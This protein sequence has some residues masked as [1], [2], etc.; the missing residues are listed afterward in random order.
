MAFDFLRHYDADIAPEL[1]AYWEKALAEG[2]VPRWE[3]REVER[4][5]AG[6]R[7]RLPPPP[8]PQPRAAEGTT[9]DPGSS[10][11]ALRPRPAGFVT[12][13]VRQVM[14]WIGT[15][16]LFGGESRRGVD[17]SA[18]T[19]A[20]YRDGFGVK[21]PRNARAQYEQGRAVSAKA[22]IPGDL[23]FFDTLDRGHVTHVGVYVGD[24]RFAHASS[25]R[26]VVIVA[27]EKPYYQHAWVGARRLFAAP[28]A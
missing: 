21:L 9:G 8:R 2:M 28:D 7:A 13:L 20:V 19:R 10:R 6:I 4:V 23:L 18:F 15:P 26:G 1:A 25:S 17:C 16:Y 27:L 3:R 24:G 11:V 22:L 14:T 5:V 12:L